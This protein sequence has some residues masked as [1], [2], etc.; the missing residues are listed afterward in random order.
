MEKSPT[1]LGLRKT[2]FFHSHAPSL[3]SIAI[4]GVHEAVACGFICAV[5]LALLICGFRLIMVNLNVS[6]VFATPLRSLLEW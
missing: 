1:T 6:K 3:I 4:I 5:L 2:A